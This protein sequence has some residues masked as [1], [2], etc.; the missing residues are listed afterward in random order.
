MPMDRRELMIAAAAGVIAPA[1]AAADTVPRPHRVLQDELDEA[2]LLNWRWHCR[3]PG[4]KRANFTGCDLSGLEIKSEI[5]GQQVLVTGLDLTETNLSGAHGSEVRFSNCLMR[6]ARMDGSQYSLIAAFDHC[7]MSEVSARSVSWGVARERGFST[8]IFN[9]VRLYGADFTNTRIRA[10][11]NNA[12]FHMARAVDADFSESS[13]T[14]SFLRVRLDRA[15]FRECRFERGSFASAWGENV[16]FSAAEFDRCNFNGA[17]LWKAKLDD[18][19]FER[20][21]FEKCF[22]R[23]IFQTFTEKDI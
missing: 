23:R 14:V 15:A 21:S 8:A 7:D 22:P 11:F 19:K 17:S 20:C 3:E 1:I 10:D 2:L 4:G 16:D 9:D 12:D 13:G 18:C 6:R 5:S